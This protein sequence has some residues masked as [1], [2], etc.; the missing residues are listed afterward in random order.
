M[1]D[2]RRSRAFVSPFVSNIPE[3]AARIPRHGLVIVYAKVVHAL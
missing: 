3:Y 1:G 2:F